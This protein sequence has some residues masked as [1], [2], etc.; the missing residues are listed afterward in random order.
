MGAD[1]VL[2][3]ILVSSALSRQNLKNLGIPYEPLDRV[4]QVT[5]FGRR[6]VWR[7]SISVGP[8]A[9]SGA[10]ASAA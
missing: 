6:R 5:R 7:E 2:A 8:R 1:Y 3:S 10:P 4:T 9:R